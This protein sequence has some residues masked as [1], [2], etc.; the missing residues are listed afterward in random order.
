VRIL[1]G[2]ARLEFPAGS[3]VYTL[4]VAEQL[5]RL[6]HDVAVVTWKE[7][8]MSERAREIGL[9]V[10][11]PEAVA[12]DRG[13][14]IIASDAATLLALAE[15]VPGAVRIMVMHST[16]YVSQTAPQVPGVPQAI[17]ALNGR[18]ARRA[19]ALAV[20]A[21]V[22]LLRQPIDVA[23]FRYLTPP[24]RPL[25]RA[26]IF[27]HL[28]AGSRPGALPDASRAAGIE[29]VIVGAQGTPTLS[30]ERIIR[31]V[32][33]V[34]GIGRCALEGIAARRPVLVI[35]PAGGDGW[36]TP[37]TFD[38]L[39]ADGFSGRAGLPAPD[40][41]ALLADPPGPEVV[42]G[43][44]ERVQREHD[45][46]L[47]AVELVELAR[48]L[49]AA[50]APTGPLA[51]LARLGRIELAAQERADSAEVELRAT[52]L[53]SR[54]MDAEIR[55]LHAE[56]ESLHAAAAGDRAALEEAVRV[57]EAGAAVL[58]A[59]V[60]E[61]E[62]ELAVRARQAAELERALEEERARS[63]ALS[64]RLLVSRA[65]RLVRRPTRADR[66]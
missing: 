37:E 65:R 25:R 13:G 21:R 4:T 1:V 15:R 61:A 22:V 17:V 33:A 55:R 14:A 58:A 24:Q 16:E 48:E 28:A 30:P 50:P 54:T 47:H 26:A 40:L 59:R 34:L 3:E 56:L 39:E 32:D 64:E 63:A 23:R 46:K 41:A 5:Q 52:V 60:E 2:Y 29:P 42:Q 7:G 62:R 36:V 19:E 57:S 10:L 9:P 20:D 27:G 51:E 49:G 35:G 18:V 66:D 6:G 8:L 38:A 44:Y 45:A 43:L 31:D 53:R 11:A 12:P